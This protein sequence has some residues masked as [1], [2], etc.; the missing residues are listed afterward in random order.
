MAAAVGYI[1]RFRATKLARATC[2]EDIV[3]IYAFGRKLVFSAPVI[4][5]AQFPAVFLA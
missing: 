5:S 2:F 4:E 1:I 3:K